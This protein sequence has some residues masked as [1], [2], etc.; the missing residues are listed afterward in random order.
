[1]AHELGVAEIRSFLGDNATGPSDEQ[2]A[3]G[4]CHRAKNVHVRGV[5]SF[6]GPRQQQSSTLLSGHSA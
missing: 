3:P 4:V 6:P 5:E 1:M 2:I